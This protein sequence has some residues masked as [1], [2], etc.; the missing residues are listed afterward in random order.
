MVDCEVYVY[1]W[2]VP[3]D[4]AQSTVVAIQNELSVASPNKTVTIFQS[5]TAAGCAKMFAGINCSHS[6]VSAFPVGAS[7]NFAVE[8]F[9][10]VKVHG[11]YADHKTLK[12]YTATVRT[13][14]TVYACSNYVLVYQ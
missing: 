13:S 9:K 12:S 5:V 4:I 2:K 8:N 11:W 6:H 10:D 7:Q 1:A 14:K 3:L